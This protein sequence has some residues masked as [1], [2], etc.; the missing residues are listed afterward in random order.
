MVMQKTPLL[1]VAEDRASRV[2]WS[3]QKEAGEI[4]GGPTNPLALKLR[5]MLQSKNS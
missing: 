4:L 5:S 3:D 1:Q 2:C